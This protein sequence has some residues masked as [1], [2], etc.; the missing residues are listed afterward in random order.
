[1]STG[2]SLIAFKQ[3]LQTALTARPA[4]AGVQ[5]AYEF[6]T[7]NITGEDIWLDRAESDSTY[8]VMRAGTKKVDEDY[9]V[10]VMIQVLKTQGEG[11]EAAD[12]RAAALLAELQQC[13]AENPQLIP[14]IQW[15]SFAGWQHL[16]GPF[17]SGG[18]ARG[19]RFEV[20]VKVRAR[21]FP[22]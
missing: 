3:A 8:P 14:Q 2:T 13:I 9:T 1:M 15:A 19:S 11:Q 18:A 6:P 21:L 16:L 4:L 12:L 7:T 22:E 5:V 20:R 10:I 17:E